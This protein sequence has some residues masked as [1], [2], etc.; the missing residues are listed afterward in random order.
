M[1]MRTRQGMWLAVALLCQAAGLRAAG[2]ESPLVDAVK[3]GNRTAVM[4][5]LKRPGAV[6]AADADG[7]TALHWAVRGDDVE[8]VRLL[9]QAGAD[10]KVANRYGIRPLG[11]AATNGSAEAIKLLLQA[12]ADP[13]A[14][15]SDGGETALMAAA[16]TGRVE[17]LR[18]LLDR[19][20]DVNAH[21][22]EYGETALMWAASENHAD[23]VRVLIEHGADKNGHSARTTAERARGRIAQGGWTAL[24]H[25][26]RQG[27]AASAA[28]LADLGVD[29]N[30]K[31]PD[32]TTAL[33][34][35]IINSHYDLAAMLLA[36]GADANVADST[37]MGPLYAA[38]DMNTLSWAIGRAAPRQVDQLDSLDTIR[39]LLE[40][41]AD[42]NAQLR[43]RKL[44]RGQ[45]GGDPD[46]GE[47]T[48]PLMRAAKTG[49]LAAMRLL[50]DYGADPSTRQKNGTTLFMIAAGMGWRGGF[51]TNRHRGTEPGA[52]ETM[53]LCLALGADINAVNNDKQNA[54]HGAVGRGE[55]VLEFLVQHG[56]DLQARDKKGQT[57]LDLAISLRDF[58]VDT[59]HVGPEIREHAVVVL[60]RLGGTTSSTVGQTPR[61]GT[62]SQSASS[63]E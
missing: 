34:V 60:R 25:A 48:T 50:L 39:L 14:A 4:T 9:L 3:A 31:A 20:A 18:L 49:D 1:A 46:L 26:S 17:P 45:N 59:D 55:S 51:D 29:L 13:N 27:A 23:A 52:I 47:G 44:A 22:T 54:L 6:N 15:V 21:E 10:A 12:G 53:K 57:P 40:W 19:G 33:L 35:A 32:G 8:M 30:A 7:T 36:K 24:L 11:L 61:P 43:T 56:A 28:A 37:G 16:R 58:D 5:I 63:P 38:V 41:G 62:A 2:S 42:P